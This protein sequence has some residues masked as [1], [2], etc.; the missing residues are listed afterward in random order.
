MSI[1]AWI[2]EFTAKLLN[3]ISK[4]LHCAPANVTSKQDLSKKVGEIVTSPPAINPLVLFKYCPPLHTLWDNRFS[5][6]FTND[7]L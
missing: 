6:S 5:L 1:I 7:I 3:I 2:F 4:K